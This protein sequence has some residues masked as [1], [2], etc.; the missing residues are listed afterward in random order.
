MDPVGARLDR[1]IAGKATFVRFLERRVGNRAD[2]EDILQGA[3]LDVAARPEALHDEAR[4][5]GWFYRV[6]RNRITDHWR[7]R[8]AA[9]RAHAA[10][11]AEIP[12]VVEPDEELYDATCRCVRDV[13]DTLEP[14]QAGLLRSLYVDGL[15]LAEVA[16]TLDIS[17]NN[18]A[19]KAHRAR[20]ALKEALLQVCRS[21]ADHG[22]LDCTCRKGRPL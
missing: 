12:T 17:K 19:V 14:R 13:V 1:L 5:F 21:C 20:V 11:A 22:C 6:L 10:A 3:L 4:L 16:E 8:A 9:T 15:P 2:A 7:R 18:A